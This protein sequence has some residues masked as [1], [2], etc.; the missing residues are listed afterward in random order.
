MTKLLALSFFKVLCLIS[1]LSSVQSKDE[2]LDQ[3]TRTQHAISINKLRENVS[4]EG[5]AKGCVVA[6]QSRT[7]PPYWYADIYSSSSAFLSSWTHG[8]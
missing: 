7:D 3:W 8:R 2:D 4:P 1:L 5:T 6:A